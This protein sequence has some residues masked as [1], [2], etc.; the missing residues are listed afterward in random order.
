MEQLDI[1]QQAIDYILS[2]LDARSMSLRSKGENRFM[3]ITPFK[4][5]QCISECTEEQTCLDVTQP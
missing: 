2:D 3:Q 4:T 1:I 5:L